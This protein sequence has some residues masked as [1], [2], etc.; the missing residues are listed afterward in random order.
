MGRV[1]DKRIIRPGEFMLCLTIDNFI[2]EHIRES[3]DRVDGDTLLLPH[4]NGE[5]WPIGLKMT[6]PGSPEPARQM[7]T[8]KL[9]NAT[10]EG[11][12]P[13]LRQ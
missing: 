4:L 7:Q 3:Q 13:I 1:S 9:V 6:G 11:Q 8:L 2:R 5:S 10:R 12:Q